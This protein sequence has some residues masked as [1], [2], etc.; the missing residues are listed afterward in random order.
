MPDAPVV[1]DIA[2][3]RR[4][5][6]GRC[7]K[8]CI[9][10]QPIS[11]KRRCA[12]CSICGQQFSQGK[13]RLQQWSNRQTNNHYVHAH[14]VNGGLVTIMNCVQSKLG[15]KK[16]LMLSPANVKPSSGQLRT[17]RYLCL[18]YRTRIKSQQLLPPVDE[19]DL[20]GREGALR[21]DDEI[22]NFQWSDNVTWDS[23][24][25]FRGTTYVQQ[26]AWFRFALQQAQN[27]ILRAIIHK[28]PSSLA[29]QPARKALVLS[30][31]LLLGRPAVNASESNCAHNLD[32]RLE[33][34]WAEDWSALW[35]MVRAECDVALVQNA[36]RRT[37]T[38]QKQSRIRKVATLA[39]AREKRRA[40]A[41]ARNAPPVPVTEQI[42]Q[43]IKSLY[44]TDPERPAPAQAFVSNVYLSEVAELIPT[45]LRKMPRLSEPGPL[46]VRAEHWY[47]FGALAGN[48]NLFVQVVAL[49]ATA[50]VPHSELQYLKG[51][52]H[53]TRQTHGWTQT[54]SDDVLFY[55]DLLSNQSF[56]PRRN[57]L[58]NVLDFYSME[59]DDQMAHTR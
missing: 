37:A 51:T 2:T 5:I 44:P 18:L 10:A 50:S 36:T 58:P 26:P 59:L 11:D 7:R 9:R 4:T 24:K 34:F 47:D 40:L 6:G 22:M 53:A 14:C 27:A 33:L 39:G 13:P 25:D 28:H 16:Q 41:A 30:C 49:I 23:I 32:A 55:A 31:W 3:P 17:Q 15:I 57:Q 35:A 8:W 12:A 56:Q 21:M 38:E 54:A 45:T 19:Q 29:F 1:H 52:D 46:G 43:E 20:F 42:V 48:S